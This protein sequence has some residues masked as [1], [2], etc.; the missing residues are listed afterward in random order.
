MTGGMCM[1]LIS[2]KEQDFLSSWAKTAESKMEKVPVCPDTYF[3]KRAG[4]QNYIVE[5][6]FNTISDMDE[7]IKRVLGDNMDDKLRR[8]CESGAFKEG[9]RQQEKDENEKGG[10]MIPEFIYTF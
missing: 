4:K 2:A 7:M 3:E 6:A 1:S 9:N 8:V 10:T 5:Y